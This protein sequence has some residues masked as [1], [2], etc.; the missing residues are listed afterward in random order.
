MLRDGTSPLFFYHSLFP[1]SFCL[2]ILRFKMYALTNICS[3]RQRK[4]DIATRIHTR[5][6]FDKENSRSRRHIYSAYKALIIKDCAE[7]FSNGRK[8]AALTHPK[9]LPPSVFAQTG[10]DYVCATSTQE[11][12]L[13]FVIHSIS[14]SLTKV[15][16]SCSCPRPRETD[17]F[18]SER[19]ARRTS[20][21][22]GENVCPESDCDIGSRR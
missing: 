12:T 21:E 20:D 18:G 17:R 11:N 6:M 1:S 14:S 10:S 7:L 4:K 19:L 16:I 5:F 3:P 22:T 13:D 2:E 8:D 15:F 9:R